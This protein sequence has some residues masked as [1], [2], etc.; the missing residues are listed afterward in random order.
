MQNIK[1]RCASILTWIVMLTKRYFRNPLF[2]MAI[3][4]IPAFVIGLKSLS[5]TD[6]AVV[7]VAVFAGE[8]AE[9]Y[10]VEAMNRLTSDKT[11]AVIFYKTDTEEELYNDVRR[12]YASSGFI[13]PK[14]LEKEIENYVESKIRQLEFDGAVIKMVDR[15]QTN[16]VKI[17]KELVFASI[18]D[19]FAMAVRNKFLSENEQ[20]ADMTEEQYEQMNSYMDEYNINEEF[21]VFELTDGSENKFFSSKTNKMLLLPVKGIIYTIILLAGMMGAVAVFNDME[22]GMFASIQIKKRKLICYLYILV[23]T[24]IAAVAGFAAIQ[25]AQIGQSVPKDLLVMILYVILVTGMCGVL[26]RLFRSLTTFVSIIPMYILMNLVLCPVFIDFSG[27]LPQIKYFRWLLPV[28]YGLSGLFSIK[29]M[30]VAIVIT[31][32]ICYRDIEEI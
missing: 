19:K 18:Y 27:F 22:N 17:A 26:M 25:F 5:S 29:Q 31:S 8:D 7:R 1:K 11:G 12:G 16:Y 23:P 14:D 24:V 20:T 2:V 30:I 32:I 15:E 3:L 4:A 28:K 13:F 9:E 21:F 10:T 6:E